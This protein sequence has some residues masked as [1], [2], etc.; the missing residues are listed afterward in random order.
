MTAKEGKL[1]TL[2][3]RMEK[4]LYKLLADE[5]QHEMRPPGTQ[6]RYI[7]KKYFS[8]KGADSKEV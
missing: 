8:V 7:L 3:I 4:S 6:I 2:T 1:K 5:A